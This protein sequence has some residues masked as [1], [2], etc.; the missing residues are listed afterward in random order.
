[1]FLLQ[2]PSEN[3]E[4]IKIKYLIQ[5]HTL[6]NFCNLRDKSVEDLIAWEADPLAFKVTALVMFISA[7]MMVVMSLKMKN[8]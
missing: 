6:L 8:R 5:S 7:Q 4:T 3:K 1:M 2:E